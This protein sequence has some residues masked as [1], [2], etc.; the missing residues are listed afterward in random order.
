MAKKLCE[1][2]GIN[3]SS[4]MLFGVAVCDECRKIYSD[5]DKLWEYVN[6]P[7]FVYNAT[8]NAKKV[9]MDKAKKYDP[10]LIK[11]AAEEQRKQ[12]ERKRKLY[13]EEQ[14]RKRKDQ[15][16]RDAFLKENGHEG[17]YEYKVISLSDNHSGSLDVD[18]LSDFLNS[19]GR[20]GWHLKCAYANELGHN[21]TSGGVGGFSTGT[22]S[23]VDQN[24]LILERFIK[25]K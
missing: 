7:N 12:E 8:P 21:S 3:Q 1:L 11:Q 19:L 14:E 2:C 16:D 10:E 13:E 9:F 6:T 20:D 4:D 25:F 23:T 15:E 17:Y 5:T 24:I 22:N 18:A